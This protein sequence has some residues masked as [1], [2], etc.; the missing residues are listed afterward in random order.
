MSDNKLTFTLT[1]NFQ[2]DLGILGLKR[3][4]D[5][6]EIE[7]ESDD[8]YYISVARDREKLLEDIIA[9]LTIDNGVEYF[10]EKV[11]ENLQSN[12][13]KKGKKKKINIE[14][15]MNISGN[16]LKSVY[17]TKELSGLSGLVEKISTIISEK[18]I[19]E[20]DNKEEEIK[21]IVWQ[22]SVNLLNNILLN[23]QADMNVKGVNTLKKVKDKLNSDIIPDFKC[24]FCNQR[25]GKRLT[26]DVFFFAPSQYNAFWFNEPSLFICPECL[27]S[28]L[29]IT[30]SF[31]FLGN[32]QDALVFYTPNLKEMEDL[33]NAL[34]AHFNALKSY[35]FAY[36]F[37]TLI[38]Y[39]KQVLK[40]EASIKEL[41]VFSFNLNSQN[42]LID[43]FI[44][45]ESSIINIIKIE[46]DII[47]LFNE[48]NTKLLYGY[49]RKGSKYIKIDFAKEFMQIIS[50]N[51]SVFYIVVKYARYCI[52][53]EIFR[54]NGTKNPPLRN[55]SP[56][57][58]LMFLKIHF[59]LEDY[60]NE[61]E[62]FQDLG[63]KIR[64]RVYMILTENKTKPINW[65][66]FDNKIISLSNSFLN[67]SK[68]SLQ[69]F[70]ELLAITIIS[71]GLNTNIDVIK[72]IN[73]DNFSEVA[74]TI[75][76][77]VLV[78]GSD[79]TRDTET[80]TTENIKEEI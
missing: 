41:Q 43:I 5:F 23:F 28:N 7:Y 1:G 2:Y 79:E 31:I 14:E 71:L 48:N 27:I 18:I 40:K 58:F 61:F 38:E 34:I 39:E 44:L 74:T 70:Q 33:N 66:T 72:S 54:Q 24:S 9:K 60:M 77:S 62:V 50:Q 64:Q 11:I 32:K 56:K 13:E 52:M 16:D 20:I 6:F 75:A 26:R 36:I 22:K 30:Q 21:A 68:A 46:E 63:Q 15:K 42:P 57:I 51:Q 47:S 67:A 49:V 73:K 69:Q 53:S 3:V 35:N 19:D 37:K 4:L 8:A 55:F 10:Y 29:A 25:E 76:L 65:N 17:K 59:K 45:Q 80:N 78:A 12:K